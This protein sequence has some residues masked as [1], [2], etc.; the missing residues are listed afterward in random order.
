MVV[1]VLQKHVALVAHSDGLL[2]PPSKPPMVGDKGSSPVL[3]YPD[4]L[5]ALSSASRS[6]RRVPE[7][8]H[9]PP[10]VATL[11]TIGDASDIWS[12]KVFSAT[13]TQYRDDRGPL[14]DVGMASSIPP[15]PSR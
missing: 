15:F 7:L 13:G 14:V 3:H 11:S 12:G 4:D 6:R 8:L 10:P 5:L 2:R 9:P 1:Q